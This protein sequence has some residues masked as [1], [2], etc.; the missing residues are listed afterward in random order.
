MLLPPEDTVVNSAA[1]V[2]A[3]AFGRTFGEGLGG[4]GGSPV[5][6]SV[7]GGGS[8]SPAT[9]GSS[10]S[11]RRQSAIWGGINSGNF[12]REAERYRAV[13]E[14]LEGSSG[15]SPK[16]GGGGGGGLSGGGGRGESHS[17]RARRKMATDPALV[18]ETRSVR[19]SRRTDA[20]SIVKKL[21][22]EFT[23][24]A[25]SLEE[26]DRLQLHDNNNSKNV[27]GAVEM[28]KSDAASGTAWIHVTVE[29][30]RVLLAAAR[31]DAILRWFRDAWRAALKPA[32]PEH[33]LSQLRRM[34]SASTSAPSSHQAPLSRSPS[35]K[36]ALGQPGDDDAGGGGG[37]DA[38][39]P[40]TK[41]RAAGSDG[42]HRR[43]SSAHGVAIFDEDFDVI[44]PDFE[45][46]DS[47]HGAGNSDPA[48]APN[49]SPKL[50][51]TQSQDLLSLLLSKDVTTSSEDATGDADG[52]GIEHGDC[53]KEKK[54][55][56]PQPPRAFDAPSATT[57]TKT[58]GG[59]HSMKSQRHRR[60]VS[61]IPAEV[62][63]ASFLADLNDDASSSA[64]SSVVA[65]RV[66]PRLDV[67]GVGGVGVVGGSDGN[68][69]ESHKTGGGTSIKEGDDVEGSATK[70]EVTKEEEKKKKAGEKGGEGEEEAEEEKEEE[71]E[72]MFLVD[73]TAPQL[74]F[75]GKDASGRFL[76]AAVNGRVVGRRA[77]RPVSVAA[78]TAAAA[79]AASSTALSP[80]SAADAIAASAAHWGRR[81]VAVQLRKVQA[82]VAP[83]DVDV[84]AGV[85]WLDEAVFAPDTQGEGRGRE[86][87]GGGNVGG[88][89]SDVDGNKRTNAT[90]YLLRQVFK[91]CAMDLEFTTHI[92]EKNKKKK[93][94]HHDHQ[95][96]HGVGGTTAAAG[97]AIVG[98]ES[99]GSAGAGE[100]GVGTG[101]G[102]GRL[103]RKTAHQGK[104]GQPQ[105]LTEFALRS[106]EIEAEM[107]AEQYA[108][109]V[110]VISTIFLA[111]LADPPPRPSAAAAALLAVEGRSL[112]EGEERASAAV[113]AGPLAAFRLARWAAVAA[114]AD[115][116]DARALMSAGSPFFFGGFAAGKGKGIVAQLL[117]P[118]S[119]LSAVE[120][121]C[122]ALVSRLSSAAAAA[123]TGVSSAVT[124][125]EALVRPN[126]RRPAI[127]LLLSV[128][129]FRWALRRGGRTFLVAAI[130]HLSLTRERHMDSS[131]MTK[132]N[133]SELALDVP[134]PRVQGARSAKA[135]A[136][137]ENVWKSVLSRWDPGGGGG[138]G[139]GSGGGG[140]A[141]HV[142]AHGDGGGHVPNDRLTI[143]DGIG[144]SDDRHHPR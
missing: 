49:R 127:K 142:D 61:E 141:D 125:A 136:A 48:D 44:V 78:A 24:N 38:S 43:S 64:S 84:N 110:D 74:N 3:D 36:A 27:P 114:A 140:G 9:P 103:P 35:T 25:D 55:E 4:G 31:R 6:P 29:A 52:D 19:I 1:A 92:P 76:L 13:I 28:Y 139:G 117:S 72:I 70:M 131:G 47:P 75:E 90:S 12:D 58:R 105:A 71:E 42:K 112:V 144:G 100:G 22:R 51:P 91:P 123:E 93:D 83:T 89:G 59:I 86:S 99:G 20:R 115:V 17:M 80:T 69:E 50:A 109:L 98:V 121:C 128:D 68:A 40:P 62:A 88:S 14:M 39:G 56:T 94:H 81:Q 8:G 134:P 126:R 130:E 65:G 111:Q 23:E 116:A 10:S 21:K 96:Q 66:P 118:S 138:G 54:K 82:H 124:S 41:K 135:W 133:L 119:S 11:L 34:A 122:D 73:I 67:P 97:S 33:S 108:A 77:R 87:G 46:I 32:V 107:T 53:E 85:Q 16:P 57:T 129:R 104:A 79:A 5:D 2:A 30:P 101:A 26:L 102:G 95:Q 120:G 106:P 63:G 60:A 37:R 143:G 18:L 137:Q 7:G 45:T 132:L 15:G 113:V